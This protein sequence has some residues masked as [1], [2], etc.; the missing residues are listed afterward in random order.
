MIVYSEL[1]RTRKEAIAA[2]FKV[3]SW[4]LPARTVE[5]VSLPG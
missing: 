2:E 4:H 3:L 5:N 1:E